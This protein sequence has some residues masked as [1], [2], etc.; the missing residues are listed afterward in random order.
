MT[1]TVDTRRALV[2]VLGRR[3]DVDGA[4][5]VAE[6]AGAGLDVRLLFV[7]WP[8]TA[9]QHTVEAAAMDE[10]ERRGVFLDLRLVLGRAALL[11]GL[12]PSSAPRISADPGEARRIERLLRRRRR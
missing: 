12:E 9:E 1:L 10:A 6:A 11:S 2:V 8:V 5:L 4:A 3:P 7:G